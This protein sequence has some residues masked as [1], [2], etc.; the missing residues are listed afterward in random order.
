ML[1]KKMEVLSKVGL[2]HENFTDSDSTN[3]KQIAK[4]GEI[5]IIIHNLFKLTPKFQVSETPERKITDYFSTSFT[6][7][8]FMEIFEDDDFSTDSE[9]TFKKSR[10]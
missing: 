4:A 7:D 10:P 2:S 3:I 1:Q 6:E 8:D 9:P 5:T